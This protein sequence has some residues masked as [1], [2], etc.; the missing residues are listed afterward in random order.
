MSK[1]VTPLPRCPH[2]AVDASGGGV[3]TPVG[4]RTRGKGEA[5]SA[6]MGK[7]QPCRLGEGSRRSGVPVRLPFLGLRWEVAWVLPCHVP[8]IVPGSRRA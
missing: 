5:T 3:G 2:D 7:H 4:L 6:S 1:L 8:G